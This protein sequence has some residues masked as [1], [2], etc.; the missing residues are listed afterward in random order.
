MVL[1]VVNRL[2]QIWD[3][4]C[5]LRRALQVVRVAQVLRKEDFV[6]MAGVAQQ[7][8]LFL[9]ARC[10]MQVCSRSSCCVRECCV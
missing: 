4:G 8:Y 5:A 9:H 3:I 6:Q 2:A 7:C 10:Q 1:A